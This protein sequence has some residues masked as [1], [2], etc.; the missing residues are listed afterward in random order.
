MWVCDLKPSLE[1]VLCIMA[2]TRAQI[3]S[4]AVQT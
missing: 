3:R 1:E 2:A 4:P